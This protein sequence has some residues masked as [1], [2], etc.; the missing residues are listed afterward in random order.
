MKNMEGEN[1]SLG[2]QSSDGYFYVSIWSM[3]LRIWL[4]IILDISE[5][6]TFA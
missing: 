3:V 2:L 5:K 1:W 4:N 6:M